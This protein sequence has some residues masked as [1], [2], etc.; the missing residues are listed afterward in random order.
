MQTRE[1]SYAGVSDDLGTRQNDPRAPVSK[2]L[3]SCR[4]TH[5]GIGFSYKNPPGRVDQ[6]QKVYAV[7]PSPRPS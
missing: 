3:D 2:R 6:R 7:A 5:S 4:P 1:V